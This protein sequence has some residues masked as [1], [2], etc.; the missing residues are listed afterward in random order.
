[1]KFQPT[2]EQV[3]IFLLTVIAALLY[4]GL[5]FMGVFS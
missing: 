3:V 2:H 1:M 5:V 4:K